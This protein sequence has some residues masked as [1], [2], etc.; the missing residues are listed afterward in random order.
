MRAIRE[1][2]RLSCDRHLTY[3]GIE[4]ALE[5]SHGTVAQVIQRFQA[6]EAVWPWGP[7]VDDGPRERWLYPGNRGRPKTR[8]EPDWAPVHQELRSR[9][10]VTLQLLWQEY[11][12]A[13]PDGYQYTQFCEHYRRYRARVDLVLRKVYH[14]GEYL[15]V[16]YAGDTLPITDPQTGAVERAQ[17]FV[18]TLGYS[19][20]TFVALHRD[21]TRASWI[22]GH[23][24]AFEYFGG[25]PRLVVPD[26]PK[27]LVLDTRHDV[28]LDPSYQEM[29]AHY[30]RGI[31]P[32]RVRRPREKAKVEGHV[33]ITEREILAPL[34]HERLG[35]WGRAQERVA[36]LTD[37]LNTRPFQA[38]AGSRR[39][40]FEADER[41]ALQ[42]LPATPYVYGAW[43]FGLTVG[44][45]YHIHLQHAAYSVPW[46]W[47]GEVVD[48]RLT[49]LT[50]EIFHQ[51]PRVATHPRATRRGQYATRD[52]HLPPHHAAVR[53]GWSPAYFQDRAAAIG[54]ETHRLVTPVLER[55]VQPEQVY[56]RC[57]GILRLA[58]TYGAEVLEQAAQRAHQT[59][60]WTVR[61]VEA[62]CVSVQTASASRPA[63]APPDHRRGA[64]YFQTAAA[65][66]GKES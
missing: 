4:Q 3:R 35:S 39:T 27:P 7:D 10:H 6:A 45:D 50:V 59:E 8:P 32:A 26:N 54:P 17:V 36:A 15:F 55:A 63:G 37:A 34:R 13:H 16:D 11:R 43:R 42:P 40:L 57:R 23:R 5:V 53:Q 60:V 51:H 44:R 38:L 47:V 19:H 14:P 31:V 62:F 2:L 66:E 33:L 20:R 22:A 61:A 25:V 29:A 46:R 48:A 24:A 30:P 41:A 56:T 65:P 9:R 21:Q 64:R 28:V 18:A 49:S 58:E 1:I 52:E 12:Q